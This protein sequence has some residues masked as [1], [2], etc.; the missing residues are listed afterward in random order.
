[1]PSLGLPIYGQSGTPGLQAR[2]WRSVDE[3]EADRE[4]AP[5]EFAEGAAELPEGFG[6]RGFLQVL[7]ASAALVLIAGGLLIGRRKK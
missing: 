6:R 2:R 1:M 3:A 4:I 7:G 5:G